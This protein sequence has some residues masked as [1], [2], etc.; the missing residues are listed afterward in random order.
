MFVCLIFVVVIFFF[1]SGITRVLVSL[2][3][4]LPLIFSVYTF[5]F[6][7]FGRIFVGVRR[8]FRTRII[9]LDGNQFDFR[10]SALEESFCSN[11][12]YFTKFVG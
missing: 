1:A 4:D 7:K 2:I 11:E 5:S 12:V 6:Q 9:L 10:T 3:E 8:S